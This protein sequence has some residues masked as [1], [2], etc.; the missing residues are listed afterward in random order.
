[1]TSAAV[2]H[3]SIPEEAAGIVDEVKQTSEE[4]G[5]TAMSWLLAQVLHTIDGKTLKTFPDVRA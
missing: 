2:E 5:S 4:F 1:M 3:G